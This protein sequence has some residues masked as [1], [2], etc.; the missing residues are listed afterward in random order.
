M[1]IPA[2]QTP[3]IIDKNLGTKLNLDSV[4]FPQTNADDRPI[5]E[6]T[7]EQKYTF[8]SKGWLLIPNALTENEVNETRDFCLQLQDNPESIPEHERSTLG[9]PLQN[10][11]IIH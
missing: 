10:W 6:L 2:S 9:G 11:P 8:D 5:I 4:N 3:F 7:Q 1:S